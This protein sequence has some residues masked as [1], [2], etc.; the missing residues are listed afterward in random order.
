[1]RKN[2]GEVCF[3]CK[4]GKHL[5]IQCQGGKRHKK[6]SSKNSKDV[7]TQRI[8]RWPEGDPMPSDPLG[9]KLAELFTNSWDWIFAEAPAK[10]KAIEWKS[11]K[12]FPLSPIQMWDHH[13]DPESLIGIRPKAQTRWQILDID[14]GSPYHPSQDPN[15]LEKIRDALEDIGICRI[16]INQSSHSGGIHL[17][18]PLPEPVSSFWLAAA[19]KFA[20]EAIAIPLKSGHCE[21]FPNPKRYLPRGRG[22]SNYAAIRLPMQPDS[23]FVPLDDDLNP[24]P[25]TLEDWFTN[26]ELLSDQQDFHRLEEALTEAKATWKV[27]KNRQPQSIASW[28]AAIAQEKSEGWTGRGQ[29][30]EKLKCFGCEARVF[31]GLDTIE[32]VAEHIYQ[33]AINSRGFQEYSRHTRD[34]RRRSYEVASWAMT[35]YWPYGSEAK[36]STSY[37]GNG[38]EKIIDFTY[39]QQLKKDSQDRIKEAVNRLR[40]KQELSRGI[41][42]RADQLILEAK[43]SRKS[44]YK[45]HN[46]ELWHPKFTPESSESKP[47]V[48]IEPAQEKRAERHTGQGCLPYAKDPRKRDR[49]QTFGTVEK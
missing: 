38:D 35:Y 3:K 30:N 41:S 20:L 13:Q 9:Q 37:H 17:Y 18:C 4:L 40:E 1:M 2:N 28:E 44:L 31:M 16:Q 25:W 6:Q 15:G 33:S 45:S 47:R 22:F 14:K 10:T 43:V 24:L 21:I 46:I 34:I 42:E 19:T 5:M 39:H 11:M 36:R 49:I 26:F 12:S 32:D 29:T 8:K 27:R 7:K 48:T 23:G